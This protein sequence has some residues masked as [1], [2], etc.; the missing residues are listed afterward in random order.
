MCGVAPAVYGGLMFRIG[1]H[2]I[3]RTGRTGAIV[4]FTN[5]NGGG[6]VV[7]ENCTLRTITGGD[8]YGVDVIVDIP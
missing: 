3:D 5:I 7:S 8:L 6:I 1:Q 4:G 2:I